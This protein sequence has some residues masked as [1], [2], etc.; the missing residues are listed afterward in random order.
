MLAAHPQGSWG[1]VQPSGGESGRRPS[2][3]GRPHI[4]L[5]PRSQPC[6]LFPLRESFFLQNGV[7]NATGSILTPRH[8]LV[9]LRASRLIPYSENTQVVLLCA[10]VSPAYRVKIKQ[11]WT[12][13]FMEHT[14]YSS[15]SEDQNIKSM[16]TGN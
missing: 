5:E 9:L 10:T 1:T 14:A 15:T 8:H 7:R 3:Q 16:L 12:L 2:I 4:A 13:P 6:F 11:A